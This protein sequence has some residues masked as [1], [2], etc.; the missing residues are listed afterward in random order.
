VRVDTNDY[1][2]NPRYVGR[3]VDVAVTLDEVVVTCEGTVVAKHR[4]CLAKHQTILA[5]AHARIL[6][7]IRAEA[8]EAAEAA[9]VDVTVEERDLAVYD[10]LYEA[11]S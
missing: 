1:S 10:Q 5:G 2:V 4:R 8:A 6:R 3:R 11:A 7:E 9:P